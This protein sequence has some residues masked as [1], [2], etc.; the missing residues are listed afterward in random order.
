MYVHFS[1]VHRHKVNHTKNNSFSH[2]ITVLFYSFCGSVKWHLWKFVHKTVVMYW[3]FKRIDFY[4]IKPLTS[5]SIYF[6]NILRFLFYLFFFCFK[7]R[8]GTNNLWIFVN[9]GTCVKQTF[10]LEYCFIYL[11]KIKDF[12]SIWIRFP[13]NFFSLVQK[14]IS[15]ASHVCDVMWLKT[16]HLH[17]INVL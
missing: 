10:L 17:I 9:S 13:R 4:I 3:I 2:F 1:I 6:N 16:N 7:Y 14:L 12:H 11:I 5:E 8:C 15:F